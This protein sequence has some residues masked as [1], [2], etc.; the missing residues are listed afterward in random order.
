MK[1]QTK[2]IEVPSPEQIVIPFLSVI[3]TVN[4]EIVSS[5]WEFIKK[6]IEHDNQYHSLQLNYEVYEDCS[7]PR[8][9]VTAESKWGQTEY[10]AESLYSFAHAIELAE[11][12]AWLRVN[13]SGS[14]V[15]GIW[16]NVHD[17]RWAIEDCDPEDSSTIH[18]YKGLLE[19]L[20]EVTK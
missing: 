2:P 15:Y 7:Y 18:F 4:G 14:M 11:E 10:I 17:L 9:T 6:V 1:N 20:E 13:G 3:N 8:Y 12:N 16:E 19:K 5:A